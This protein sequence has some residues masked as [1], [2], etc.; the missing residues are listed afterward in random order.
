[1]ADIASSQFELESSVKKSA[2]YESVVDIAPRQTGP[3][4]S[5]ADSRA[6]LVIR[7]GSHSNGSSVNKSAVDASIEES[8][9]SQIGLESSATQNCLK[10]PFFWDSAI[11]ADS[12]E[13]SG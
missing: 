10:W 7:P 2:V 6:G 11:I 5:V 12:L 9:C 1:M 4:S 8:V 3:E 13:I